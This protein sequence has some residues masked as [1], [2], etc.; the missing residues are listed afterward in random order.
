MTTIR[1][2]LFKAKRLDGQ[3]VEGYYF[4]DLS[5]SHFIKIARNN[6]MGSFEI[7]PH[8]LCQFTGLTDKDGN[9]IWEKRYS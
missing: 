9:K 1:E 3:W 7:N 8:T 5:N 4:T 6:R 2:I